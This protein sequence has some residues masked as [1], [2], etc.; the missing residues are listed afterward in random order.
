MEYKE[1]KTDVSN[2]IFYRLVLLIT[3]CLLVL[4]NFIE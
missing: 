2:D 4:L 1:C 3:P